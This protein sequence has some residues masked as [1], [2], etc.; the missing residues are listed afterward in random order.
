MDSIPFI[1]SNL[2]PARLASFT[3]RS[4]DDP[5]PATAQ[6]NVNRLDGQPAL[7]E[8]SEGSQGRARKE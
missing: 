1:R 5:I 7:K 6:G 3:R 4:P 8:V 2:S